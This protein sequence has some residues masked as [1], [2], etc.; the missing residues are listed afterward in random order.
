M[1]AEKPKETAFWDVAALEAEKDTST[2]RADRWRKAARNWL[3]HYVEHKARH[4]IVQTVEN[5]VKLGNGS[6]ILDVGCGPGKWVKLQRRLLKAILGKKSLSF[7]TSCTRRFYDWSKS[8]SKL[9]L[10]DIS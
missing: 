6:Q 4:F 5:N 9:F 8:E 1:E 2:I 10:N 3:A 7:I